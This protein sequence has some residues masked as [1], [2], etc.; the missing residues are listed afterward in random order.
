MDDLT[1][2]LGIKLLIFCTLFVGL[3]VGA[4]A[5]RG[6]FEH[7]K[8]SKGPP[9]GRYDPPRPEPMPPSGSDGAVF[10]SDSELDRLCAERAQRA[11]RSEH[12]E[13]SVVEALV[14]EPLLAEI[15]PL[16]ARVSGS[17]RNERH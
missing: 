10:L 7:D 17:R 11:A 12:D 3:S 15:R 8:P 6:R 16:A 1:I 9:T 2:R 4:K 5:L 13:V 14:A